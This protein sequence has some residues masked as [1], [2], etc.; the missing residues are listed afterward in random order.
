MS[1]A[2]TKALQT[3]LSLPSLERAALVD[4]L[5]LSL[6]Q[7][8]EKIDAIWAA[9]AERRLARYEAGGVATV[10]DEEVFAEYDAD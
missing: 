6:D 10:S 8:D 5:I 3:A 1:E 7:P 9:E 4:E 2:A